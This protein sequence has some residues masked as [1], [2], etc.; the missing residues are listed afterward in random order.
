[1]RLLWDYMKKKHKKCLEQYLAQRKPARNV[2]FLFLLLGA[3]IIIIII[4]FI[5]TWEVIF[6]ILFWFFIAS[7]Y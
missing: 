6:E 5:I 7:F 4:I 1:M 3:I 2:I